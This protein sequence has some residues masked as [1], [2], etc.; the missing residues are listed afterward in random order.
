M[1]TQ[2]D[3]LQSRGQ[4][5]SSHRT[6]QGKRTKTEPSLLPN[7]D[8]LQENVKN[9]FALGHIRGK[10]LHKPQY[11]I[12]KT[13]IQQKRDE[14]YGKVNNK[15][16]TKKLTFLKFGFRMHEKKNNYYLQPLIK[17]VHD[18]FGE[19]AND[20]S[21][22]VVDLW[23]DRNVNRLMDAIE[24]TRDNLLVRRMGKEKQKSDEP[25]LNRANEKKVNNIFKSSDDD[26]FKIKFQLTDVEKRRLTR[27]AMPTLCYQIRHGDPNEGIAA[28]VHSID[29]LH[30]ENLEIYTNLYQQIKRIQKNIK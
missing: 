14:T 28:I 5:S 25:G 3:N 15:S 10:W 16:K 22:G 29:E 9:Q 11:I 4:V 2:R 19:L 20:G 24:M 6:F 8:I 1:N 13:E 30:Q 18:A 27:I 21:M 26:T 23:S 17:Q 7:F 12:P